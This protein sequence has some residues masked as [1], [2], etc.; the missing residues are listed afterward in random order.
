MTTKTSNTCTCSSLI[1]P[2][3][4]DLLEEQRETKFNINAKNINFNSIQFSFGLKLLM[5]KKKTIGDNDMPM[6][7]AG[8]QLR[9]EQGFIVAQ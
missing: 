4:R 9:N 8:K 2:L 5:V 7:L 6:T 3:K 1:S